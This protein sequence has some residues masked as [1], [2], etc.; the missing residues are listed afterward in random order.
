MEAIV[1]GERYYSRREE[2]WRA[3]QECVNR[4]PNKMYR[5]EHAEYLAGIM[6]NPSNE[7]MSLSVAPGNAAPPVFSGDSVRAREAYSARRGVSDGGESASARCQRRAMRPARCGAVAAYRVQA[8]QH[9]ACRVRVEEI[10]RWGT[11]CASGGCL[12]RSLVWSPPAAQHTRF[13]VAYNAR[14][15]CC[16]RKYSVMI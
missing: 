16:A 13:S 5:R 8:V 11:A 1:K 9:V 12:V 15:V 10:Q 6:L 7:C 2:A 4:L 14:Y 3:R